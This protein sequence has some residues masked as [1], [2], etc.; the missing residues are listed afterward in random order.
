MVVLFCCFVV[1]Q[2]WT[3]YHI[4][5]TTYFI[6]HT[7]YCILYVT[8]D[9]LYIIYYIFDRVWY[10]PYLLY[11]HLVWTLSRRTH[12][13]QFPQNPKGLRQIRDLRP[14]TESSWRG[15]LTSVWYIIGNHFHNVRTICAKQNRILLVERSC[16]KVSDLSEVP[17]FAGKWILHTML[18]ILS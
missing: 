8:H 10:V 1:L 3:T 18:N 2:S 12:K 13:N 15:E 14:R 16:A 4:L 6:I 7:L 5:C 9:T 17:W 11:I